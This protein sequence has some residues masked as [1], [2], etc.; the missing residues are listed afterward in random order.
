M[1][2]LKDDILDVSGPKEVALGSEDV[3]VL[4]VVRDGAWFVPEFLAHYNA[5]VA[6]HIVLLDN[7]SI[8]STIS[9]AKDYDYVTVLYT[10]LSYKAY[11]A[12]GFKRYLLDRF[13]LGRWA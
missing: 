6:K 13:A 3:I 2:L 8:D 1:C 9:L 11:G 5:L 12:N 4:C 7:A 10:E